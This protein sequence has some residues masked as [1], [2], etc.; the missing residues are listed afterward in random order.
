MRPSA[1]PAQ[2]LSPP[3]WTAR[4]WRRT[5]PPKKSLDT[6]SGRTLQDWRT[7]HQA[8]TRL[9]DYLRYAGYNG[10]ML[11]VAAD[12][13]T[14]YPSQVLEPTPRYDTGVFFA[15]G[16]DPMPK[17]VLEMLLRLIDRENLQLIPSLEFATPLPALEA[18]RRRGGAEAQG[19]EWI[20]A[21]GATWCQTYSA[22]RGLAPYYNTLDPRVQEAMLA[23]VRELVRRY[24]TTP[25]SAAW[26]S[27]FRP[28][29]TPNFPV[30]T[31]AWTTPPSPASSTTPACRCPAR[32]KNGSPPAPRSSPPTNNAAAGCNGGPRSATS[33]ITASRRRL[34][35]RGPKCRSTW[36]GRKCS[37]ARKSRPNSAPPC[38]GGPRSP[39]PSCTSAS[40]SASY[41]DDAQV[42]LLRPQRILPAAQL[43][44]Q[45]M[46][47]ELAQM[48]EAAS[49]FRN[50]PHSG[51]L[52][53]HPPQEVRVPSFDQKVAIKSSYALLLSQVVP[54]GVQNRQRFAESL[55]A[56]DSQIL[57]DGGWM[58]PLGQED[59][60]HRFAAAFRQLPPVHFTDAEE[61]HS[62]QP[63]IFRAAAV[64]GKSYAY[65]VNTTPFPA[66]AQVRLT[67]SPNCTIDDLSGSGR[68]GRLKNEGDGLSWVI[69]LEPYDLAAVAFSEPDV[70]LLQPQAALAGNVAES[71]AQRIRQLSARAV[72][73]R[74]PPLLKVLENPGFQS[75][76]S[77]SDPVPGW[78]V[79]RRL[80]VSVT[81][82]TTQGHETDLVAAKGS[83]PAQSAQPPQ[84]AKIS[85]DGPIACLVSQAFVPPRTGRITMS[86]WLRV[87]D[88]AGSPICGW[89]WKASS[90]AE[91]IIVT[92][93]SGSR[94]APART[95]RRLPPP[96]VSI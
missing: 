91:I 90:S 94:R 82:D 67:A 79:S 2:R 74:N 64:E 61:S 65:A 20:G 18:I 12:G 7:F 73:L 93:S 38:R 96:G 83:R 50:L 32:A 68:P 55:F 40:T 71:M 92:P 36:P 80:G 51:S 10:L 3:T 70:K 48:S 37:P 35:R 29:A 78:T 84:S 9:V 47:L 13:S 16:Q 17:D 58:L 25:V 49:F 54:S 26:P 31:G 72:A 4:C 77:E 1:A 46:D 24:A 8:G 66:T 15:S 6:W 87:A 89:P 62:G 85:S 22:R 5:S 42:V 11:S 75:K 44:A 39:P 21:D 19:L 63:V 95:V 43:T 30:P 23:A 14:I 81:T 69:E 86:V 76:P 57:I 28:T 27:G 59:S 41:R 56:H 53:F 34:P 88:A 45:A 52:F 33:S 60:T